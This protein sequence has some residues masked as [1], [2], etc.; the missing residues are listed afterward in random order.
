MPTKPIVISLFCGPGGLDLG[1]ENAG[2]EIGLA[3]DSS[4]DAVTTYN[5]NRKRKDGIA[6]RFDLAP[7]GTADNVIKLWTDCRGAK[8]SPMGIIGGPP[9]QSFSIGNTRKMADDPR[10][11]LPLA[12]ARILTAFNNRFDLDFFVFENVA[13]LGHRR[14]GSS[15]ELFKRKFAAAGFSV[16]SF[17]LDAVNHGVPQFRNRMF[18]LGFNAQR[19]QASA[20]CP[21]EGSTD[22]KT[23]E[24]AISGLPE[25]V[26]FQR[27]LDPDSIK[28]HRNHWCM[29]PRSSKFENGT[30]IAGESKGRSFR[31]LEWTE[32]SRTV[33]YG[34]R[35]VHIHPGGKRRL[36]VFEAMLLQGFPDSYELCGNLSAQFRQVSDAVPPP[37]GKALADGIFRFLNPV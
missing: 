31:R 34:H 3:L 32:P 15:L 17:F 24:E 19:W 23:V 29:N 22:F 16:T 6:K 1:F 28:H 30:L 37:L 33:A 21:P 11:A 10:S 8:T 5:H 4:Q 2:F 35:E 9:C 13:G 14:H 26:R 12:Y 20:F 36:S 27:D 25:P 7:R 18:I